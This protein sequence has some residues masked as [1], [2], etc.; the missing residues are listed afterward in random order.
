MLASALG[1]SSQ[2]LAGCG[3]LSNGRGWG[4]DATFTP[5][6][7]RIRTSAWKNAT[8][9]WTWAP[10]AGVLTLQIDDFDE[11]ISRWARE[12][13][14]VYG[15][16]R[17]ADDFSDQAATALGGLWLA[18]VAATKSGTT[19]DT[20]LWSKTKGVA[21]E[22]SSQLASYGITELFK[23]SVRRQRPSEEDDFSFPS[24]HTTSAFNHALLASLNLDSTDLSE[25]WR[26][27][28][29]F[30]LYT[31]AIGTGWARVEA[32]EHFPVDVLF[33]AGVTNFLT[34][35]IHD[36]FL[37]LDSNPALIVSPGPEGSGWAIGL[38]W[39]F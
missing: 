39:S 15:S 23:N 3:T 31:L 28:V 6:W 18:S 22:V 33:A 7:D 9:P 34:G 12:E 10:L 1:L 17:N 5:G 30:G 37:G 24:G 11:R 36:A 14:P 20:Y 27:P 25:Q 35:F 19:S 16:R 2:L 38:A 29:R 21:V 13:T 8:D 26:D 4:Q 32:G